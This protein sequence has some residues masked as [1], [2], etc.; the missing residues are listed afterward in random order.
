[1]ARFP[2][3]MYPQQDYHSGGI[4]FGATTKNRGDRQ[5]AACDLIAPP[6]TPVLAVE[7]GWVQSV[8][9]TAYYQNTYTVTIVHSTF[10]VRYCELAREGRVAEHVEVQEGDQIGVVGLNNKGRGML[11]FEMYKGGISGFLSQKN[12][13]KYL[14]VPE[15]NYQRRK[16]L[17]DPT[18]YLDRW[19]TWTDWSQDVSEYSEEPNYSSY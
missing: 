12:N 4:S 19:L 2:L 5:H 1:M 16:D 9:K 17:L 6:G 15:R 10:T 8:P 14:Y 7:R 11:H 13:T 18:P 3:P